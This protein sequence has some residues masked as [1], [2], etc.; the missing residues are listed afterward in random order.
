MHLRP[1]CL[2]F[3]FLDG[4]QINPVYE[5]R[6]SRL[7]P[8]VPSWA[9]ITLRSAALPVA[10]HLKRPQCLMNWCELSF[11]TS[12]SGGSR[13]PPCNSGIK[14]VHD[15]FPLGSCCQERIFQA[16]RWVPIQKPQQTLWSLDV[17]TPQATCC[18]RKKTRPLIHSSGLLHPPWVGG[19][20]GRALHLDG[21]LK[22][23]RSQLPHPWPGACSATKREAREARG[24][25]PA[26]FSP[27]P[28]A[29]S[30]EKEN[31]ELSFSNSRP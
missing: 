19:C 17:R 2:K 8:F 1:S 28:C 29:T 12:L 25:P 31:K 15:L 11:I 16:L 4:Y 14:K 9:P 10:Y 18:H 26:F 23:L 5:L 24:V 3:R 13:V 22:L 27:P 7:F 30:S 21:S 20:R 6:A